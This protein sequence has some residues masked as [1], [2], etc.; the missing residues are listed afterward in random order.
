MYAPS[1]FPSLNR[2]PKTH[3]KIH[4][5]AS[6]IVENANTASEEQQKV[7]DKDESPKL[8]P[9]ESLMM[10]LTLDDPLSG[11]ENG[12]GGSGSGEEQTSDTSF[13]ATTLKESM[14]N[15]NIHEEYFPTPPNE[16]VHPCCNYDDRIH[17]LDWYFAVLR[18]QCLLKQLNR[19]GLDAEFVDDHRALLVPFIRMQLDIGQTSPGS[20]CGNLKNANGNVEE[21]KHSLLFF[22][23]R[24]FEMECVKLS[25]KRARRRSHEPKDCARSPRP[26]FFRCVSGNG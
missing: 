6:S 12:E 8:E 10:A 13:I 5:G 18:L 25:S 15:D 4:I 14:S 7:T 20:S 21:V 17:A 22:F 19:S 23:F 11:P 1:V 3:T 9:A 24:L 16:N 26:T 2:T